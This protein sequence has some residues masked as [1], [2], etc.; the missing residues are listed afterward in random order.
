MS[1][2]TAVLHPLRV[3]NFSNCSPPTVPFLLFC[4]AFSYS[5]GQT[6][7]AEFDYENRIT[8][9]IATDFIRSS[10]PITAITFIGRVSPSHEY[11]IG[12]KKYPLF[13]HLLTIYM[14]NKR[15]WGSVMLN[16][17]GVP[18]HYSALLSIEETEQIRSVAPAITNTIY[19]I[20]YLGNKAVVKFK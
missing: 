5:Y 14:D 17:H 8:T 12:E 16:R 1:N 11:Q 18:L 7:K 6:L 2:Y 19:E 13:P 10:Q 3:L 4:F 9:L 15:Y 20:Y